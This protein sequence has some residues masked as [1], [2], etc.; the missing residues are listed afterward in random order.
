M[1]AVINDSAKIP[2]HRPA[3][4]TMSLKWAHLKSF[5]EFPALHIL[6][7]ESS[8]DKC[9][10]R[11]LEPNNKSSVLTSPVCSES[12]ILQLLLKTSIIYI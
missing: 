12:F 8:A 3:D 4:I 5:Q 2:G 1:F 7:V 9:T 6:S 10:M 11:L